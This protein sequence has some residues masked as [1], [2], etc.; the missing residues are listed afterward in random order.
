MQ[1]AVQLD[2]DGLVTMGTDR[3]DLA[4]DIFLSQLP[5]HE[6]RRN[7]VDRSSRVDLLAGVEPDAVRCRL[8]R[9]RISPNDLASLVAK[10]ERHPFLQLVQDFLCP[11]PREAYLARDF[12][13]RDRRPAA[14][15]LQNDEIPDFVVIFPHK[16]YPV[17]PALRAAFD[18]TLPDRTRDAHEVLPQAQ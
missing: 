15:K 4:G 9:H 14:G 12:L 17:S 10:E 7:R 8:S 5:L 18:L 16:A 1:V 6:G 3:I 13:G 2:M 11:L